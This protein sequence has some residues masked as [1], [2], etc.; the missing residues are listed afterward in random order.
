MKLI[1]FDAGELKASFGFDISI[2]PFPAGP[3]PVSIII[4]GSAGIEGHFAIGYSTRGIR[5]A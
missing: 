5:E 2:G 1:E 4:G 3:V